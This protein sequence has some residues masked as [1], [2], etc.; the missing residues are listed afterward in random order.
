MSGVIITGMDKVQK[1]NATLMK[2]SNYYVPIDIILAE[3]VR[4]MKRTAPR[5]TGE[6]EESIRLFKRGKERIIAVAVPYA[7][8][9]EYGTQY[10]PVGTVNAPRARTSTSGK[11]CYHPF[12]RPAVWK[13]M[14]EFPKEVRKA[15][16]RR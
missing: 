15:L 2:P 11:P 10:F 4:E 13:T 8:Y 1:L 7:K 3:T 6:L 16:F 14:R 12:M 5:F 9:M